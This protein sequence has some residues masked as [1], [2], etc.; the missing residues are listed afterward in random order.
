MSRMEAPPLF[1]TYSN[2]LK[3]NILCQTK[4]FLPS[5]YWV[6]SSQKCKVILV[7][8]IDKEQVVSL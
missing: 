1:N 5:L 3:F 7:T 4:R 6:T 8:T 2:V